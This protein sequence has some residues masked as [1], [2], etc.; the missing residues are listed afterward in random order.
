MA[1]L[2][3]KIATEHSRRNN[4][5]SYLMDF[6]SSSNGFQEPQTNTI[7]AEP[8]RHD[9]SL[10]RGMFR[11]RDSRQYLKNNEI[12]K[13]KEIV[14]RSSIV[15]CH[16]QQAPRSHSVGE[17]ILME[18]TNQAENLDLGRD[19]WEQD[20]VWIPATPFKD[21]VQEIERV[22]DEETLIT[23]KAVHLRS[24]RLEES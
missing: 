7:S 5:I 4:D 16:Q 17:E 3:K 19:S 14:I 1:R 22:C 18:R 23:P 15:P 13:T 2:I 12:K 9:F 24:H 21:S 6:A 8:R 10:I 11:S 20:R